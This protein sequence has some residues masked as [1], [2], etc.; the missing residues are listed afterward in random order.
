MMAAHSYLPTKVSEEFVLLA[1][2]NSC[3]L[4]NA[5]LQ[6]VFKLIYGG[7]HLTDDECSCITSMFRISA[8]KQSLL[9][10]D[11]LHVMVNTRTV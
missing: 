5:A 9:E 11:P 1:L 2:A 8:S 7:M 10:W 3:I 4:M 6:A